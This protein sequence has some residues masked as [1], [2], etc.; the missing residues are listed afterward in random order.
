MTSLV[1]SGIA[2]RISSGAYPAESLL[3]SV[4]ELSEEFEC[5]EAVV[6]GALT[7]LAV[8][9]LIAP[10]ASGGY[11]V[12]A[13]PTNP[14]NEIRR[15][16]QVLELRSAFEQ[17]TAALAAHRRTED[18][19]DELSAAFAATQD[20]P[21]D[22]HE[23]FAAADMRLHL[24]IIRA[25]GNPLFIKAIEPHVDDAV[26][27]MVHRQ[28]QLNNASRSA[29]V[30][31]TNRE[32]GLIVSAIARRDASDARRQLKRHFQLPLRRYRVLLGLRAETSD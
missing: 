23:A 20:I 6:Q 27:D 18:Q 9:G 32:H 5:S 14:I 2:D 31:R 7:G 16:F 8:S 24:A 25:A 12:C 15:S 30:K 22:D 26:R 21:F 11:R 29:F 1:A 28:K 10:F 3:P 17:E 19:L 4:Y 13:P